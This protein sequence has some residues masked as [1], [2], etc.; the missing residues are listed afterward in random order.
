MRLGDFCTTNIKSYSEKENW[1]VIYYLDTSN[2][3]KGK[4]SEIQ[5]LI[6]DIDKIPSR[7]KRKVSE[8]DILFSTVRPNQR[9][10]GII[11]KEIPY[12]LVSTGFAVITVNKKIADE[13]YI[14]Y[15]LT[16][17]QIIE[18]LQTIAEQST[19]AYPSIKPTDIE[20]IEINLPTLSVQKAIGNLL[21][22][23][24][25]KIEV[26]NRIND[27]LQ[28]QALA[29]F[30]N[31]FFDINELPV[32]WSKGYLLDIADYLNG[33]AMQKFRP[34]NGEI[35]L[36]VL[37]IKELRQGTCDTSSEFCSPA[38]KDEFIVHDGDVI[39]S[40]SGSL[41]VDFWCGGTCGLNQHLFKV[42]SSVYDKWF[43]Y[44]WT[45]YHLK[46]FIAIATDKATTMGHIK[47][48]ELSKSEVIIPSD[49]DYQEINA[50][51]KPI[52]DLI[53]ANRIAN[54][55]FAKI[56]DKL[57]PRLMSGEI[58]VSNLHI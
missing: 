57:L 24:D 36:P 26:N 46:R 3:T 52:I 42:T 32:G 7:A 37:K 51:L 23:L 13:D 47:R 21:R 56:R 15:F 41:L 35:G 48:E 16:Q 10:Y 29:I 27:N 5:T 20:N 11:K 43:Y 22:A 6:P 31:Y 53:V 58:D 50:T 4:I 17:D 34:S 39:F 40:W 8:G 12:L 38:I 25:E 45:T 49:A 44:L 2:L 28:H 18:H 9:H 19:S 33:L 55:K 1:N 54:R 30:Q 14:Y